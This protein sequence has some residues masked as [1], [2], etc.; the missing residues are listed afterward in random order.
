MRPLLALLALVLLAA[1]T[2]AAHAAVRTGT[3]TSHAAIADL[4]RDG[5][6]DI[7]VGGPNGTLRVRLGDGKG[8]FRTPPGRAV[9]IAD[10]IH[11]LVAA[12]FDGDRR[13]DL[14][15]Y[16][17]K[18]SVVLL[19][20]DGRGRFRMLRRIALRHQAWSIVPGR[21]DPGATTDLALT[22]EGASLMVLLGDGRGGMRYAAGNRRNACPYCYYATSADLTGDGRTDLLG[23]FGHGGG[24]LQAMLGGRRDGFL[25]DAPK[26]RGDTGRYPS[27]IAVADFDGDRRLDAAVAVPYRS[28]LALFPGTRR[29]TFPSRRL[30]PRVGQHPRQ[31]VAGDLNGD[32]NADLVTKGGYAPALD[33]LLG[34]GEG[35]FRLV[36]TEE[37]GKP[38][39]ADTNAV[40]MAA[41]DL[42]GD[43]RT[44]IL[45]GRSFGLSV[46]LAN[47]DGS[48]PA[49]VVL[50]PPRP[51]D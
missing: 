10:G 13:L 25:P 47:A 2:P 16:T 31:V 41:G 38:E 23:S 49:P 5:R 48:L 34:D 30:S 42:N 3:S 32:G 12:D 19:R 39:R 35:G 21:F 44:D 28:R 24:G 29:G 4:N 45:T 6:A 26:P 22:G 51:E 27:E 8:A 7:A 18:R 15:T 50:I 36:S 20:G 14:A 9:R 11:E 40:W 37:P 17:R 46:R 33:V 1:H 43:G